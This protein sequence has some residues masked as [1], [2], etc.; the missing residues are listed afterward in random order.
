MAIQLL[1]SLENHALQKVIPRITG[2]KIVTK[3]KKQQTKS[4]QTLFVEMA[5]LPLAA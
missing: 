4:N 3:S 1:H 2:I 5:H